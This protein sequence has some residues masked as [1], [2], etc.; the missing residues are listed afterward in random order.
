MVV[1]AHIGLL[2]YST[3]FIPPRGTYRPLKPLASFS[4]KRE[5][6]FPPVPPEDLF[7]GDPVA[8]GA[9]SRFAGIS[10]AVPLAPET[11]CHSCVP[12]GGS[13]DFHHPAPNAF[14]PLPSSHRCLSRS[15]PAPLYLWVQA[16]RLV[17]ARCT[18]GDAER[19][20]MP[21]CPP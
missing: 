15:R 19:R 14:T 1:E 2:G 18:G 7:K 6:W 10:G 8:R 21:G 3:A 16:P 5:S 12:S 9:H 4:H 17:D 11:H 13:P 20:Q